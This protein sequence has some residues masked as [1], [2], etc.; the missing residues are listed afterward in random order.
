MNSENDKTLHPV[1]VC[2][3]RNVMARLPEYEY[4]KDRQPYVSDKDGRLYFDM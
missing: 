4:I 1:L 2:V 3:I